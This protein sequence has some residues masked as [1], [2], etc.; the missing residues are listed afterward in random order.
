MSPAATK[1]PA[2]E[3][4]A[5][6]RR[7]RDETIPAP[8][9]LPKNFELPKNATLIL[10]SSGLLS[11]D[12]KDIINLDAT[13]LAAA[14]KDGTYTSVQATTAYLKAASLAQQGT[15]C[16]VEM[17]ADEAL[18]RA[19]VLDAAQAAGQPLGIL[20]GVPVS[21]KDHIDVEGHDSPSGFLGLVGK[22]MAASDAHMVS[23][24]RDAGAV[25]YCKTTNPQSLMHLETEGYLGITASPYNTDLT[26][27]GSSGGEG[28]LIGMKGSPFGI[29]TDIGGSVRS[30]AAACGIYSFKPSV[31]RLPYGGCNV[32]IGPAGCEA[33]L[34]SHGPMGRSAR[35]METYM[36]LVSASEP[37]RVDPTLHVKPWRV[38][39]AK[40]GR[41]LRV[42]V[43]RDDGVVLPVA[44]I[45]RALDTAVDKLKATGDF[46][47]V[48][49]TPFKSAENWDIISKLYWLDNGKL[50][51]EQ[52]AVTDE[53]VVPLTDWIIQQAGGVDR[54][55]DETYA[56]VAKRDAF[57]SEL[58]QYWH[59]QDVDVVLT[60]VGPSPAPQH[61]TAKYWNYTSYW[62]LANYPAAVFPTGMF[63]DPAI[64]QED[65]GYTPRNDKDKYVRDTYDAQVSVGAPLCLQV[66]GYLGYEEETLDALKK[67]DAVVNA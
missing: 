44:P 2:S 56:L 18:E 51:Y 60:P 54:T 5:A 3:L 37:W 63:V 59:E 67:I 7:A 38:V 48:E 16:L 32:P 21:I 14:I 66:V 24:L 39:K 9:R 28:A 42:G 58:A 17:F 46:E 43:L 50:V 31:G 47:I 4:M 12:E 20:H 62:N 64:D 6:A 49:Y 8:Y 22:M 65:A 35:D 13:G 41:K 29:G 11:P 34:G 10:E 19:A 53:P 36:R 52:I 55:K 33:I 40:P 15:N 23:I 27:G 1:P 25:F 57:R 61:G 30:P 45:R 26:A